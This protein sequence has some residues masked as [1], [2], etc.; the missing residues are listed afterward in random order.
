[1]SRAMLKTTSSPVTPW[2]ADDDLAPDAVPVPRLAP[3]PALVH[4]PA[5]V[6]AAAVVAITRGGSLPHPH[7]DKSHPARLC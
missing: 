7:Q 3:E 1:M 6:V 2:D 4:R 5:D